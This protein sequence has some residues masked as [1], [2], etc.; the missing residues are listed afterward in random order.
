MAAAAISFKRCG[1]VNATQRLKSL[2]YS[3][4]AFPSDLSLLQD[5][6]VPDAYVFWLKSRV[7][8]RKGML[9]YNVSPVPLS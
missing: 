7:T 8:P 6:A 9:A 3:S 2:S 1:P 4:Q 5:F